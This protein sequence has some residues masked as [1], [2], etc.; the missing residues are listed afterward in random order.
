V[1]TSSTGAYLSGWIPIGQYT[2]TVSKTG[3]TTQQMTGTVTSGQTVTLNL[4]VQ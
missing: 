1:T 3:Y 2:V 4:T